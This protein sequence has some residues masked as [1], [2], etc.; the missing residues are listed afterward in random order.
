MTHRLQYNSKLRVG[1]L[2]A[3]KLEP[4]LRVLE[5]LLLVS[6]PARSLAFLIDDRGARTAGERWTLRLVSTL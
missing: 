2:E 6:A 4:N 3:A 1:P 5:K